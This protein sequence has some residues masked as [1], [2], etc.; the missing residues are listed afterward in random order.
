M[1]WGVVEVTPEPGYRLS[2]GSGMVRAAMCSCGPEELTGVLE[3]LRGAH[4]FSR[5][6]IDSGAVAWPRD[7]DL[8]P[9]E[10]TPR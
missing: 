5:A 8:A 10:C 3:P 2:Y 4:F 1:Y 6:Y 7:I 9:D